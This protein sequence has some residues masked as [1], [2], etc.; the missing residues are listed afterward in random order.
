MKLSLL[1]KN[2]NISSHR[3]GNLMALTAVV[4][5]SYDSMQV[6]RYAQQIIITIIHVTGYVKILV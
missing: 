5:S 6:E 1:H 2:F 3:Q 4:S